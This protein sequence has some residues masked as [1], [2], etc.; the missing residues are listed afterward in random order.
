MKLV[1]VDG[2]SHERVDCRVWELA[3]AEGSWDRAQHV[4]LITPMSG[5]LATRMEVLGAAK[6]ARAE[7][8]ADTRKQGD[9]FKP[10]HRGPKKPP[11]AAAGASDLP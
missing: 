4:E 11:A 6:E 2:T 5:M 9:R 7:A 10:T 3:D 1:I 8:R